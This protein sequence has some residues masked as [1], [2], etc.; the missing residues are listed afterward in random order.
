MYYTSSAIKSIQV[1][2]KDVRKL[3]KEP[4]N[5]QAE[6]GFPDERPNSVKIRSGGPKHPTLSKGDGLELSVCNCVRFEARRA[7]LASNDRQNFVTA[8]II[9]SA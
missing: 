5:F 6:V 3:F 4:K 9:V 1:G 2:L 7:K 8:R